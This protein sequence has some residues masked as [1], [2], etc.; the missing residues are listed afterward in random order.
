M[1]MIAKTI[2]GKEFC[3]SRESAHRASDRGAAAICAALNSQRYKLKDGEKW[4]VYD[5]GWYESQNTGAAYQEFTRRN[6]TIYEKR[7]KSA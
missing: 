2:A 4:H 3:Y 6:G 1:K 7:A 5:C